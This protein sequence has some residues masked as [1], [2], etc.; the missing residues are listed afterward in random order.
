M[1][2]PV[3]EGWVRKN[4]SAIATLEYGKSPNDVRNT[5]GAYD[6]V[7]TSGIV[8]K[9]SEYLWDQESVII[10]RKG[11]I[12][13]P[14]HIDTP[15]WAIDTTYFSKF[16]DATMP[17]WFY[18]QTCHEKLENHNEASGVPSLS[19]DTL[20][21]ISILTPPLPEQKKIASILTSVDDV[22][23][24]TSAQI[25]KL[26][27]L[28]QGMMQEL[29]TK[30]IGHTEFKDS[31]VG[32]I[33]KSWDV[34]QVDEIKGNIPYS[35]VGG[36]FG[37]DLTSKDYVADPGVPVIR[38]V[39]LSDAWE[40]FHDADFVFV[41]EDKASQLNRN[42][43]RPGDFVFTQRGT[44]GQVGIIPQ[45]AKHDSYII[46]QSQMKLT[47]NVDIL[48]L[49]YLYQYFRSPVFLKLIDLST[50]ATGLPHINLGILKALPVPIPGRDEQCRI[51]KTLLS[52]DKKI[53]GKL[54]VLESVRLLKRSLMQDLLTGK[55]RVK[56]S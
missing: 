54:M 27:D 36:P 40:K 16:P 52:V 34:K 47:P 31:P 21:S 33:P 35:L 46:S 32:R 11:T 13:K 7:G 2:D 51:A 48:N 28:K 43:A 4:L 22:I 10:G 44:L 5:D 20:N 8:G 19:R 49:E 3:P 38:G 26:Q 42:S 41:S 56:V 23:E 29:L 6:I 18:Y 15:F 1:S 30:G 12:N 17:K 45:N 25:S 55:V 50:I 9:A 53:S 39:N 24:K 14:M 37:S